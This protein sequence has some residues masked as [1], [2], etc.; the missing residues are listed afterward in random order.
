MG[1]NDGVS[2]EDWFLIKRILNEDKKSEVFKGDPECLVCTI[3]DFFEAENI[4]ELNED[5]ITLMP[6]IAEEWRESDARHP[7]MFEEHITPCYH[8]PAVVRFYTHL[9]KL[10]PEQ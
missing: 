4:E 7:I 2:E 8:A 1:H 9:Y 3:L 6:A 10:G 5:Q